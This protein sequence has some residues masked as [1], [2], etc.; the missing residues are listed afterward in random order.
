MVENVV[1]LGTEVQSTRF[2]F[3]DTWECPEQAGVSVIDSGGAHHVA[4]GIAKISFSRLRECVLIEEIL[5]C[6][7]AR[8][9]SYQIGPVWIATDSDAGVVTAHRDVQGSSGLKTAD[10]R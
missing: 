5:P 4:S 9:I 2:R 10:P 3:E 8:P 6:T 7:V 1:E